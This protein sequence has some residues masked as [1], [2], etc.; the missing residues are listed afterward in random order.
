LIS[1]HR[2]PQQVVGSAASL[3]WNQTVIYSDG[4]D[5]QR[6]GEEWLR[7]TRLQIERMRAAREAISSKR[8]IDVHYSAMDDDW[9][10]TMAR[11]YRFL[12]L[13]MEPALPAMKRFIDRSRRLKQRPHRYSLEQF[14]LSPQLV[15]E[16]LGDYVRSYDIS[17]ESDERRPSGAAA[18]MN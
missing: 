10:G 6:V 18:A 13:E 5:P 15:R 3:A 7:K 16:Q 12:G 14:G 9:Q 4:V 11:V 1:T 8:M 2:D 17:V